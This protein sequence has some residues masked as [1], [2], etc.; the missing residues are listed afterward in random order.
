[1]T[2]PELMAQNQPAQ[3]PLILSGAE[4]ARVLDPDQ[5]LTRLAQAFVVVSDGRA[6]IPPRPA[7]NAPDGLLS[8]MPGYLPGIGLGSKLVSVYPGNEARGLPTHLAVISLFDEATGAIVCLMDGVHVTTAR[9]AGAAALSTRL[10]ARP[11]ASVL[12]ILGAGVEGAAHLE[13]IPRVRPIEEIRIASRTHA[14]AERL[15]SRDPRARAVAGVEEAVHGADIVCCCTDA[16]T[17]ILEFGW[18][19][20]GTHVTSVGFNVRGSE[21]DP[22]TVT[23]GHLFVE[24]RDAF[25]PPPAGCYELQSLDPGLGTELGELIAGRAPGRRSEEEVTVYRSMGHA[26]EDL[27]A[28]RLVYEGAEATGV[29]TRVGL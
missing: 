20:P 4:V 18:L 19:A 9:T 12:A 21:L 14:H 8:V 22:A 16:A 15:A 2:D 5:L 27:A 6:S 7:A 23:G 26:A 25:A 11:D 24:T 17:P 13:A 28:A 29:G 3:R 1:M 10:L